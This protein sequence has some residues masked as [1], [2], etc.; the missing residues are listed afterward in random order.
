MYLFIRQSESG[1]APIEAIMP[2]MVRM[3]LYRLIKD[4][5]GTVLGVENVKMAD[6]KSHECLAV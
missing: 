6:F 5:L 1:K 4:P 3:P 2:E